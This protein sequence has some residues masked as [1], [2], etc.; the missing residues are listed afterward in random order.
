[1]NEKVENGD[2]KTDL[3]KENYSGQ[4]KYICTECG[5]SFTRKSSLIVHQRVHTGEKLFM[6]TQCGKRFSLKSSMVRHLRIH[7]PKAGNFICPDCGKCFPRYSSLFQHQKVHK[8][9]G[10]YRNCEYGKSF[11]QTSELVVH[12]KIHGRNAVDHVPTLHRAEEDNV[13]KKGF[14]KSNSLIRHQGRHNAKPLLPAVSV[15]G[16]PNGSSIGHKSD[17]DT[18]SR[19]VRTNGCGQLEDEYNHTEGTMNSIERRVV[20][21]E[22]G[23]SFTRKSSLIVHQR[24]HTGEKRF[25]C[26]QCGKRFG[27]KSSMV[28]HLRT[29]SPK[30]LNICPDCG[31]CFN[32]YASL[33]QHQKVHRRQKSFQ[34]EKS[35]CGASHQR[36]RTALTTFLEPDSDDRDQ[37]TNNEGTTEEPHMDPSCGESFLEQ[38]MFQEHQGKYFIDAVGDTRTFSSACETG[39]R[40]EE[41][42]NAH[43]KDACNTSQLHLVEKHSMYIGN[44]AQKL[45]RSAKEHFLCAECGKSFTRKSSLIVHQRVHTGEKLFI[46]TQ[47]GKRFSLKSSMV[48]HLR[49]HIPKAGNFICPDCGK[50]FP[51][52]SSLFQHQK[53]H[54]RVKPYECSQCEKSFRH[55]SQLVVHLKTH[56]AQTLNLK[57]E[58]KRNNNCINGGAGESHVCWQCGQQFWQQDLLLRHQMVHTASDT[59]SNNLMNAENID[60]QGCDTKDDFSE[61]RNCTHLSSCKTRDNGS[62]KASQGLVFSGV[63]SAECTKATKS[64]PDGRSN[65][66]EKPY[67]CIECGKYFTRKSSL[68]VHQ[69]VHTGEKL[70]MCTECRRSFSF[71]SSLVRHMRTHTGKPPNICSQCGICL[72]RYQDLSVH[73]EIHNGQLPLN[74]DEVLKM[75]PDEQQWLEDIQRSSD[76][77]NTVAP[78]MNELESALLDRAQ[79]SRDNPCLL[80]GA[81]VINCVASSCTNV[82]EITQ[83]DSPN[84]KE[85]DLENPCT[86]GE[87]LEKYTNGEMTACPYSAGWGLEFDVSKALNKENSEMMEN[88]ESSLEKT[89]LKNAA[90]SSLGVST[91]VHGSDED[92][93]A[94]SGGNRFLCAE[95]GK[96]FTRKS[97]LIVHQRVHTGEKSFMCTKCGKMFGLKSSMVRHMRTHS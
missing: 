86:A 53:V 37:S 26:A 18:S 91:W 15:C 27:L 60:F 87:H 79:M 97:S 61:E 7:I 30:I 45:V 35:F 22:C 4:K 17:S 75:E 51:R 57:A 77:D 96:S 72:D 16:L 40:G 65:S 14:R 46:C 36:K 85:E 32:R 12:Q 48:R 19:L 69:R 29:H 66:R 44:K 1:M 43:H 89:T 2:H 24:V 20:C 90:N 13:C 3:G 63:E 68:I 21:A 42:R 31:K 84:I 11:V 95:C 59:S 25:V 71:K 67:H 81:P 8:G 64:N 92:S 52:Y 78:L 39:A 49:I 9:D 83:D 28:R 54:R 50:C 47:C 93:R 76:A 5:K 80:P 82:K 33:V 6:C 55:T 73:M 94:Q 10:H 38:G 62:G 74:P 88:I 41:S 23:K 70:Y 56:K 34:C 58:D